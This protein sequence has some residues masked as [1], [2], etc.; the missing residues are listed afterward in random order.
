MIGFVSKKKYNKLQEDYLLALKKCKELED[1]LNGIKPCRNSGRFCESC[2][3]GIKV[4][5]FYGT[6]YYLCEL[7]VN[8]KDYRRK[9]SN[10]SNEN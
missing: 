9:G 5:P 10:K 8:C 7:N 2:V 4:N 6:F 3:H 1:Q